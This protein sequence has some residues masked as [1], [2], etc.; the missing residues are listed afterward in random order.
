[1]NAYEI[2]ENAN[3]D[4]DHNKITLGEWEKRIEPTKNVKHI[5]RGEWKY[6]LIQP[7]HCVSDMEMTCTRCHAVI[8]RK[9]GEWFNFCPMCGADMRKESEEEE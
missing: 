3:Y 2:I 9:H 7:S 8:R 5:V 1:M 6:K 4:L